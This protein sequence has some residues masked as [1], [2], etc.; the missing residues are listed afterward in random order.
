MTEDANKIIRA[1]DRIYGGRSAVPE[2]RLLEHLDGGYYLP[3]LSILH[4]AF[5]L[6]EADFFDVEMLQYLRSKREVLNL[7]KDHG[8]TGDRTGYFHTI[9]VAWAPKSVSSLDEFVFIQDSSADPGRRVWPVSA[10]H[11]ET[12]HLRSTLTA[13][14]GRVLGLELRQKQNDYYAKRRS[15]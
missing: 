4:W 3:C 11:F 1:A 13:E 7:E 2:Q 9:Y 6:Q 15:R 10:P 5:G 12:I 14:G 8:G